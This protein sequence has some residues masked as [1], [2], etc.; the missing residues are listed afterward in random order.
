MSI[1]SSYS[2]APEDPIFGLNAI[3]KNDSR[4]HKIDLLIGYYRDEHGKTPIF[5][6][7]KEAENFYLTQRKDLSYLPIDGLKEFT[8]EISKLV[9][10]DEFIPFSYGAQTVGGTSAL[11]HLGALL[12]NKE[13]KVISIPNP[14]WANHRQ[15]FEYLGYKVDSYPYFN[16]HESTLCF[17]EMKQHI[18][19]LEEGSIVLL[20]ASCHNPSGLDLS[21]H[22]WTEIAKIVQEKKLFPLFDCAYQG[23]GEGIKQDVT[24]INIFCEQLKEL[25][26]AYSCSKNFGMY[27]ERVG[28]C[29]IFSKFQDEKEKAA[30]IIKKSLRATF[31]NPPRHGA[32]LC[33]KV[34]SSPN[35]KTLWEE[36]LKSYLDRIQHYR[37]KLKKALLNHHINPDYIACAHGLFMFTGL[38]PEKVKELREDT[39]IYLASDGRL[40][41]TGLNENNFNQVYTSL[42]KYL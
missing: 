40:N 13:K 35:L 24:S 20:H 8:S 11:H 23:F 34:L 33:A 37:S 41:I 31:S 19:G 39:G 6:S 5:Q 30:S 7:I 29:F 42:I 27:G 32:Y 3:M 15:I 9:F 36:E 28:A 25:A 1:F 21:A 17:D 26:V 10:Y 18:T 4:D 14:S 2:K 22:Q 12:K 16:M 38:S